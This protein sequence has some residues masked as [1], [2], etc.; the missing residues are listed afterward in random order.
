MGE[1][2]E[3]ERE[4]LMHFLLVCLAYGNRLAEFGGD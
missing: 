4:F 1:E 2:N 3:R